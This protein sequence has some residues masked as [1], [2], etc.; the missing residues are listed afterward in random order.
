ML[1]FCNRHKQQGID[2]C[3]ECDNENP[4]YVRYAII[5]VSVDHNWL[6]DNGEYADTS[7]GWEEI[8]KDLRGVMRSRLGDPVKIQFEEWEDGG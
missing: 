1:I 3:D 6:T 8:E 5:S 2:S 7:G 4:T